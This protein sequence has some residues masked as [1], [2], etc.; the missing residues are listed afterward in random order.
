MFLDAELKEIM[1]IPLPEQTS[2]NPV[3]SEDLATVFYCAGDK[4]HALDVATGISRMVRQQNCQWQTLQ[5]SWFEDSVLQC[6]VID[7]DMSVYTCFLS[8]ETGQLL[9][10]DASL[11]Q[12]YGLL[13]QG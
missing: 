8:A 11:Y 10:Q 12:F 2:G 6:Y 1:R 4:V 5:G 3:I 13:Q 9:G 7:E